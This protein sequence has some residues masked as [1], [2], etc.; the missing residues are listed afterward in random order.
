MEYIK[1]A[2]IGNALKYHSNYNGDCSGRYLEL[3][4]KLTYNYTGAPGIR[5]S[6]LLDDYF[7]KVNVSNLQEAINRLKIIEINRNK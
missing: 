7:K 2:K 1:I 6:K 5:V 3:I 4:D